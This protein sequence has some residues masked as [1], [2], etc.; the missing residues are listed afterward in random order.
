MGVISSVGSGGWPSLLVS[1][2][3]PPRVALQCWSLLFVSHGLDAK[4]CSRESM[5]RPNLLAM[6]RIR[7]PAGRLL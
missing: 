3:A 5:C 1:R 7:R 6:V 2:E 4:T